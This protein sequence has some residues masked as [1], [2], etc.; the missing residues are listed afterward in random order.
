[1]H[2]PLFSSDSSRCLTPTI[3][4]PQQNQCC[5]SL[6]YSYFFLSLSLKGLFPFSSLTSVPPIFSAISPVTKDELSMTCLMPTLPL[7]P[8]SDPFLPKPPLCLLHCLFLPSLLTVIQNKHTSP[9]LSNSLLIT[10]TSPATVLL[11]FYH[12]TLPS[13]FYTYCLQITPLFS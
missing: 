13:L 7:V 10:L 2:H 5:V 4:W 8:S 9:H 1:M 11:L 6:K 12:K 3:L